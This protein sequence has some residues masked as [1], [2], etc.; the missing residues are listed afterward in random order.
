[1]NFGKRYIYSLLFIL[2][3]KG[4]TTR[5]WRHFLKRWSP[6][7]TFA[8]AQSR[9]QS[10]VPLDQRSEN[11]SSG[12][13]RF[14]ILTI[15]NN[16]ILIIQSRS[17]SPRVFWSAP[18]HGVLALTKGHVGSGNE[19]AGYP[20]HCAVSD[21]IYG[22]CLKWMLPELSFFDRWS[23][24]TKL[25]EWD[26]RLRNDHQ[27][28]ALPVSRLS[29]KEC[30]GTWKWGRKPSIP[31]P[32]CFFLWQK[33]VIQNIDGTLIQ[34]AEFEM[35]KMKWNGKRDLIILNKIALYFGLQYKPSVSFHFGHFCR[36]DQCAVYIL[37]SKIPLIGLLLW[38]YS[39][40]IPF[41]I[42]NPWQVSGHSFRWIS[43]IYL[44][45]A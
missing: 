3:G 17:Q 8:L 24:G 37:Y 43:L 45:P 5:S 13:I 33:F 6:T 12:S 10:F 28:H 38:L 9:S 16:R 15:E 31:S 14:E 29:S 42:C 25:W 30:N 32:S 41:E 19:I 39:F 21:C 26:W 35:T 23:R 11:E 27:G 4:S 34:T 20:A 18:R 2:L 40:L 7:C 44:R 36:L 1:M 22:A